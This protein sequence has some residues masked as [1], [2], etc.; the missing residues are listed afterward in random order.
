MNNK[1]VFITGSAKRLGA[2][3]ARRLHN[4]GF[5]VVLHCNHSLT[6]AQ[7]LLTEL[8]NIRANSAKLVQGDLSEL[9]SLENIAGAALSAFNR[10]D[11][12]INNASA[13]YPTPI[14]SITATDWQNLVG[15]NMQAPLFISQYCCKALQEQNGVIINMVDIHAQHPL[16]HHTV[17][18]MAKS[19]LVTMTKSLA[20]EL[21]PAVRV[22]GVAPGAILWPESEISELDKQEILKQIPAQ[23]LGEL[24]DIAQ[25]IEYL[26]EAS[27]VTGQIIAVDG[28]RSISSFSKA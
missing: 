25:A 15:S 19:A 24:N 13:F 12:L 8:N 14:G 16:K 18:C 26:I 4:A 1:V 23:R 28:G 7:E 20:L 17:Y 10:L 5:N 27:Y 21:A 3:T 6:E 9:D 11:V 2:F 22:N